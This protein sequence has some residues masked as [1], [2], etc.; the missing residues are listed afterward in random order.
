[1]KS[2]QQ[3][4][5]ESLVVEAKETFTFQFM[6]FDEENWQSSSQDPD[7]YMSFMYVDKEKK[8]KA[9]DWNDATDMAEKLLKKEY[10]YPDVV[11][12]CVTD[13]DDDQTITGD[14]FFDDADIDF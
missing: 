11:A 9:N 2:L 1:M 13:G 12:I 3:Y 8:I 7:D 14:N 10:D 4:F 5:N 6:K